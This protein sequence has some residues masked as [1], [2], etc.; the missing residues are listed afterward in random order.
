MKN[1]YNNLAAE[2]PPFLQSRSR[3]A[4]CVGDLRT[5]AL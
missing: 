5:L 4:R 1:H 3:E 2:R